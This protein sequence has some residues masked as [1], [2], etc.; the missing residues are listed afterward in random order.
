MAQPTQAA[1]L[2]A[3]TAAAITA[4]GFIGWSPDP[5]RTTYVLTSANKI[6]PA[7][8]ASPTERRKQFFR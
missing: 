5:V 3:E 4:N 2:V 1:G 7:D 6:G 8:V